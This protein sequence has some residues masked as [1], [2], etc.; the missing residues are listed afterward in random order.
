MIPPVPCVIAFVT[1]PNIETARKIARLTLEQGLTA[2]ANILP[3]IESIYWWEEKLETSSEVLIIFKTT[4]DRQLQLRECVLANHPYEVPEFVAFNI[5]QG[6][7][8]YL[9]W[10]RKNAVPRQSP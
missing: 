8:P 1:A 2:C 7:E 9:Q 6:S 3:L 10:I 4:S 5:D